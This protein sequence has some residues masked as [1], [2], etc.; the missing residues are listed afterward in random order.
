MLELL[1]DHYG[2]KWNEIFAVLVWFRDGEGDRAGRRRA[3]AEGEEPAGPC[4]VEDA[5][6]GS[7]QLPL[8]LHRSHGVLEQG[9]EWL[10]AK[11]CWE[12]T[13]AS[14]DR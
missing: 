1:W 5:A 12:D 4:E 8:L 6:L 3:R 2:V 13:K 14:L 7:Q 9:T 10:Q 11:V